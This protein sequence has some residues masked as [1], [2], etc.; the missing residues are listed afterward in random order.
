MAWAI[1]ATM[2]SAAPVSYT[3]L[4]VYKRQPWYGR[5]RDARSALDVDDPDSL[6]ARDQLKAIYAP[7]IGMLGSKIYMAGRRGYAP[8]RRHM[9][10]AK[11]RTNILRR[12]AKIGQ[13]TDR[14]PV[15]SIADTVLY[16]SSSA[17]PVVSWPGGTQWLGR[18]LGKYKV[19]G[20]SLIHI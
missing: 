3:H 11:A 20:L 12:V 4:E 7:T 1:A 18:D 19:E 17:D 9:I 5:V 6:V 13:E 16:T 15:A 8:D 14:W 2:A 10:I